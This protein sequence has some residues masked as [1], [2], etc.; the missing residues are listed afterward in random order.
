MNAT[1][2]FLRTLTENLQAALVAN[3][4]DL[5]AYTLTEGDIREAVSTAFSPEA[6]LEARQRL[7]EI[8]RRDFPDC[9]PDEY[10]LDEGA[11]DYIIRAIA[12][13]LVGDLEVR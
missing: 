2:P 8:F 1:T 10:C 6:I 4:E 3:S 13:A 12:E 9:G 5:G 11:E 7:L